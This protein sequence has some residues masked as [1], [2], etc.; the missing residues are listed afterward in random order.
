M[1]ASSAQ[2]EDFAD[3]DE[4]RRLITIGSELSANPKAMNQQEEILRL[5][6]EAAA[7][8]ARAW[9]R[10]AGPPRRVVWHPGRDS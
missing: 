6:D 10:T 5:F 8:G 1:A 2:D 3:G 4:P 7:A 9:Q